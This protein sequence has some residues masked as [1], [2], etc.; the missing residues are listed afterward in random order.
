MTLKTLLNIIQVNF[1][2]G[3]IWLSHLVLLVKLALRNKMHNTVRLGTQNK[4]VDQWQ[5][6]LDCGWTSHELLVHVQI[7]AC[8]Y[9]VMRTLFLYGSR[10]GHKPQSL[11]KPPHQA[12]SNRI[13]RGQLGLFPLNF[14]KLKFCIVLILNLI[15]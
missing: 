10:E 13:E 11:I 14:P 8:I 9:W 5:G 2:R 1:H 4:R 6:Q 3:E 12:T 7:R 15:I